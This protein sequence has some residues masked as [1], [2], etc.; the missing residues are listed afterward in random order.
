MDKKTA[1]KIRRDLLKLGSSP[2]AIEK[3]LKE[4][5]KFIKESNIKGV[6]SENI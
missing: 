4:V 5:P 2:K 1:D 6:Q 3:F